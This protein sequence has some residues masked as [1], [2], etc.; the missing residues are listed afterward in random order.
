[1]TDKNFAI[2]KADKLNRKNSAEIKKRCEHVKRTTFAEN[3]NKDLHHLD[4]CVIGAEMGATSS[5]WLELF[6]IRYKELEHYK[7]P[8]SRKLNSNAVIGI[9]VVTSMSHDMGDKINIDAW[10]DA[11][12]K[13]MQDHFGKDNVLHG[14]LHLDEATPHIHYFVT[15]VLDGK[16]N[17]TKIMGN[18]AKYRALQT[19]YAQSVEP[20]GLRRGLKRGYRAKHQEIT[21]LYATRQDITDLPKMSNYETA[22]E[23]YK[24]MNFDY[25]GLQARIK[26][27]EQEIEDYK[28]TQDYATDLEKKYET[29]EDEHKKLIEKNKRLEHNFKYRRLG[30]YLVEDLIY[31]IEQYPDK[32]VAANYLS[33]ITPLNDWGK[34]FNDRI[35]REGE[36][37]SI[38][39]ID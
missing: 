25:R 7:D 34:K 39:G 13:W 1:M 38:D 4:R 20:F 27:L 26:Y 8:K 16:F 12:N 15:P 33:Q 14:I 6:K 5:N 24:K 22:D 10:V 11:T 36:H 37:R 2:I 35:E 21:Q 31:A 30:D 23:Y 3:V 29:L 32:D 9:E 19:E 17:A 18:K 28:I